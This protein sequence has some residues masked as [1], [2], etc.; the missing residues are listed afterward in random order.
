MIRKKRTE[1]GNTSWS[2][3]ETGVVKRGNVPRNPMWDLGRV[4]LSLHCHETHQTAQL[5]I[6]Q[7]L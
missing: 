4:E 5:Q 7:N 2:R 6:A 1:L 3:A